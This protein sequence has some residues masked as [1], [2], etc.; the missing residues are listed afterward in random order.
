VK[1]FIT[2]MCAA[3]LIA[4]G[5]GPGDDA[6]DT[7]DGTTSSTPVTTAAGATTTTEA[8]TT[9]APETTT[10]VAPETTTTVAPATTLAPVPVT[11][12]PNYPSALGRHL[13]PWTDVGPGWYLAIYD[14]GD[15]T[16]PFTDGP[17]VAYLAAP[18]GTRY[19]AATWPAGT[20]APQ[21]LDWRPDG[22]A[23][24]LRFIDPAT[25]EKV[26]RIVDLTSGAETEVLRTPELELSDVRFTRPTGTNLVF[27]RNDGANERIE[28]RAP[29]GSLLATLA[30]QPYSAGPPGL[31]WLY[32]YD[33]TDVVIGSDAGMELIGNDGT[34]IRD[35]WT[36]M[37]NTCRPVRWW[38]A[39]TL[40]AACTGEGPAFPHDH[41][42]RL[43]LIP[44][45]GTATDP[46]TDFPPG[47]IDI[48]D[49][50]ISDGWPTS[51]AIL[52]QWTGDCGAAGIYR[53][54]T[55]TQ[56]DPLPA[57]APLGSELM[58]GIAGG[59]I[60]VL[61]WEP[62]DEPRSLVALGTD[63]AFLRNLVPLVGDARGVFGALGLAGVYP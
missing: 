50:G 26:T 51:S 28:R 45:D 19:E 54:V 55:P 16:A 13:V 29:D 33:G 59:E 9:T 22:M 3:A 46:L 40:L 8:A 6:S 57:A 7:T 36:P 12:G 2:V 24:L 52:V 1:R 14:G 27:Y 15:Y 32:G 21:L 39:S 31:D 30:D 20:M 10:S 17:V 5:C 11:S 60:G 44:R 63:G 56:W 48:V 18:D 58:L 38:N 4:A 42:H 61:T 62:C 49:F 47:P 43:F 53:R 35:L 23:A 34:L 41:Y 25:F 37:G